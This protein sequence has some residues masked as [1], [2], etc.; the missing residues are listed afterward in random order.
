MYYTHEYSDER[1]ETLEDC[2]DDLMQCVDI[3]E[4]DWRI[5][6]TEI[7]RHFFR[8]KTDDEFCDWLENRII[9]IEDE[10]KNDLIFDHEGDIEE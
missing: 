1:Y 5:G 9:E 10:I 7:L 2:E 6:S 8:R 3:D 4:Y